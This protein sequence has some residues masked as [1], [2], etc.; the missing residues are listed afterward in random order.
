MGK[1]QTQIA[2]ILMSMPIL[3]W[4]TEHVEK[5][6]PQAQFSFQHQ[7]FSIGSQVQ[8]ERFKRDGMANPGNNQA[9]S[10]FQSSDLFGRMNQYDATFSYP[11]HTNKNFNFDLGVNLRFIDGDMIQNG[12]EQSQVRFN[13]AMPMLYANALYSLPNSGLSA[14]IGASHFEY[15]Q[16]YALDYKAKLRYQWEAGFG[17]EGGWQHQQLT[18]D[19]PDIQAEIQNTGPFLDFNYRF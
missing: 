8:D 18:I 11:F 17:L 4:S 1:L 7:S 9:R 19:G 10:Q 14:S 13:T 16:Y 3:A 2:L 5:E 12:L 15:D 6:M